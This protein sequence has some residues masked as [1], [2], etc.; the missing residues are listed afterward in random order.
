MRP[1]Y[2]PSHLSHSASSRREGTIP[3]APFHSTRCGLLGKIDSASY[4]RGFQRSTLRI[5]QYV[6][7]VFVN[8]ATDIRNLLVDLAAGRLTVA[9]T[10]SPKF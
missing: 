1:Q 6:R 3:S 10:R 7:V 2:Q 8:I 9:D 4:T 5:K